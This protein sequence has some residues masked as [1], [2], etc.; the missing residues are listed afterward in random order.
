VANRP[1][2]ENHAEA[3]AWHL[4]KAN[5]PI[6]LSQRDHIAVAQVEALLALAEA[7]RNQGT[8]DQHRT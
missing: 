4:E 1:R 6:A 7:V 2:P 8:H 5:Q 3:A